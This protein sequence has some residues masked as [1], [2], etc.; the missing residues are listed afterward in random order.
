MTNNS[1]IIQQ[2]FDFHNS[3]TFSDM[4][5]LTYQRHCTYAESHN[6]DYWHV[7][8]TLYPDMITNTQGGGWCKIGLIQ[9]ALK[10]GYDYIA[11]IDAD[12]AITSECDLRDALPAGKFIGAAHHDAPWFPQY[13]ILPHYN[14]GVT[15][16]RNNP[17]VL[18]FTQD[19][20]S[21]YPGDMRW[22]EQG[23]FNAMIAEDKYKDL[24]APV[25]AKWNATINVNEVEKPNIMGWHGVMPE[26]RRFS[27][28][29]EVFKDDFI[30]YRI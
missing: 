21:R 11:W 6:F 28:M 14:I 2:C 12:A 23:T 9:M 19:W 25:E 22:M 15:Y 10:R 13:Q 17:L 29:K 3:H 26:A 27:M 16:W 5:H 7:L 4:M 30:K 8:G 18:E 1:V 20:L 24:F